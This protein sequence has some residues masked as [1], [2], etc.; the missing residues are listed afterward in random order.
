FAS[1]AGRLPCAAVAG[2]TPSVQWAARG[3]GR[4]FW[5]ETNSL[6]QNFYCLPSLSL[7]FSHENWSLRLWCRNLTDTE[8]DVFY[9]K[10]IGNSFVQQGRPREFGATLRLRF[11]RMRTY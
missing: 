5:D 8:Y 2:V 11:G 6:K 7:D 3:A 1:A 9:F 4:I 10:S